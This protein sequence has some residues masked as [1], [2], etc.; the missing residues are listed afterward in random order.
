MCNVIR[1]RDICKKCHSKNTKQ[2]K[3][4]Y[5]KQCWRM[6][7]VI[8][9]RDICKECHL[10]NIK[11][12]SLDLIEDCGISVYSVKSQNYCRLHKLVHYEFSELGIR[13]NKDFHPV[14]T[15]EEIWNADTWTR[16]D[17]FKFKNKHKKEQIKKCI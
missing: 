6:C 9:K 17:E 4:T 7:N 8:H 16:D 15:W 2:L 14:N 1:E 3:K 11:P 5:C 13:T 10:K 12:Y